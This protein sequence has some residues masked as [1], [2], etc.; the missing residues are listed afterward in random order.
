MPNQ[1]QSFGSASAQPSKRSRGIWG[2]LGSLVLLLGLAFAALGGGS[3]VDGEPLQAALTSGYL[4]PGAPTIT[5]FDP[6]SGAPGDIVYLEGV[7]FAPAENENTVMF[8]EKQATVQTLTGTKEEGTMAV[9]VPE[10]VGGDIA[11]S[12]TTTRGTALSSGLFTVVESVPV[13]TG[14]DPAVAAIGDLLYID[15][16]NLGTNPRD[17]IVKFTA[18][19]GG[20][21]RALNVDIIYRGGEPVLEVLVPA[22][23]ATGHFTVEV[24]GLVADSGT[25]F[26]VVARAA[27]TPQILALSGQMLNLGETLIVEGTGLLDRSTGAASA[28]GVS[29]FFNGVAGTITNFSTGLSGQD[30]LMVVV[31]TGATDGYLTIQNQGKTAIS[32]VPLTIKNT[33][34]GLNA[35]KI[36]WARTYVSPANPTTDTSVLDF[37][38]FVSDTDG[39]ADLT[40]VNIDLTAFGGSPGTPMAAGVSEGMG[41]FFSLTGTLTEQLKVADSPYQIPLT[42]T[43]QSGKTDKG[44]LLICLGGCP[45]D[46]VAA[47]ISRGDTALAG[48]SAEAATTLT[49]QFS[50]EVLGS[51]LNQNGANFTI[52]SAAGELAVRAATLDPTKKTITLTTDRQAPDTAYALMITS[53]R[54]LNG[55]PVIVTGGTAQFVGFSTLK[56]PVSV[57]AAA[58][59]TGLRVSWQ[60]PTDSLATG[61]RVLYSTVSGSYAHIVEAGA[62][63]GTTL[64]NLTAGQRYYLVVQSYDTT[65]QLSPQSAEITAIYDPNA[66][67]RG[68]APVYGA[69]TTSLT[70][71]PEFNFTNAAFTPETGLYATA[72]AIGAFAVPEA[73]FYSAANQPVGLIQV[74]PAETL[75]LAAL[76]SLFLAGGFVLVRRST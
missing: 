22:N 56:A 46:L 52:T 59:Q 20:V 51:T 68:S 17:N 3:P 38:T 43:D 15:G 65:G 18:L 32:R 10:G 42:A 29:V 64:A 8:G 19:D 24:D 30:V 25:D 61:H 47:N 55:S 13:I 62:A 27:D 36:D 70:G 31:P 23:T 9:V 63:T 34:T 57:Q 60:V 37:Y 21:V 5:S 12:V 76:V 69:T 66:P 45:T 75:L 33:A 35:P 67:L 41:Q 44:A 73:S 2:G 71:I 26:V 49:L 16:D 14:F 54:G 6:N 28:T 11:I 40:A 4:A 53:L 74:G 50:Q 1:N 58:D 7:N 39:A 72:T 48:V